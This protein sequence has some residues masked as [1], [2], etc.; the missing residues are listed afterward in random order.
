MA[1][2]TRAAK[3]PKRLQAGA[4]RL[5]A[6]P[7]CYRVAMRLIIPLL[8]LA[9]FAYPA[10]D[11]AGFQSWSAAELKALGNNIS[12]KAKADLPA[13]QQLPGFGNYGFLAVY[14][15]GTGQSELHETQADIFVIQSGEGTLVYGGKMVEGKTT[16]PNEVRGSGIQGGL[17]KKIGP[18]DVL[19]VPAKTPHQVKLAPG[20]EIYYLTVKITQ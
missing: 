14:R 12:P 9:G 15:K 17:E 19:T 20:K 2:E 6:R 16:A 3:P 11:P 1:F 7:T 4:G 8:L 10:G 13:T 5:D 18:G